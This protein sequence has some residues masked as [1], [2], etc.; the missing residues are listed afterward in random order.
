[1]G[2]GG[3]SSGGSSGSAHRSVYVPAPAAGPSAAS[4]FER[5]APWQRPMMNASRNGS[6]VGVRRFFRVGLVPLRLKAFQQRRPD[7]RF[8]WTVEH[9]KRRHRVHRLACCWSPWHA[10]GLLLYFG[11]RLGR[12]GMSFRVTIG[13]FRHSFPPKLLGP[14]KALPSTKAKRR[15]FPNASLSHSALGLHF[16]T[17]PR[18]L[19]SCNARSGDQLLQ[20]HDRRA[21]T[22][23]QDLN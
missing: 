11:A 3:R 10:L 2:G 20:L 6:L 16:R 15:R 22:R 7:D 5:T 19:G 17:L 18:L 1:M 14:R 8:H 9:A 12:Y 13:L 21:L 4:G 23:E